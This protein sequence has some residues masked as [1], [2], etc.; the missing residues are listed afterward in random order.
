[1][2]EGIP[3]FQPVAE[4]PYGNRLERVPDTNPVDELGPQTPEQRADLVAALAESGA[5]NFP[6]QK[7]S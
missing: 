4:T 1:M 7:K 2:K 3:K 5:P 6:D